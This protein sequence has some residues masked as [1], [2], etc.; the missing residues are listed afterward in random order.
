MLHDFL[1][2]RDV[3][4]LKLMSVFNGKIFIDVL[5]KTIWHDYKNA[6]IQARNRMQKLKKNFNL[7]LLKNTGLQ[8]PR[9]AFVMSEFCKDIV[10]TLFDISISSNITLSAVTAKH[11]SMEMISYYW[12]NKIG[13]DV[14]RTIVKEWSKSNKHTPD[15]FYTQNNKRIYVEIE[16]NLKSP[17]AYNSLF[18][19]LIKDDVYKILYV[20]ENEK[21]VKQFANNLPKSDKIM[22]ISIDEL[23]QNCS[24]NGKIGAKSQK[25]IIG[26]NK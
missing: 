22:I 12:L 10:R 25:E 8:S 18:V 15:L 20:V 23:I 2:E 9:S 4:I 6:P 24:V 17:G 16:R 21:R 19:N 5:A 7:F 3:E 13:R 14:K 1:T 26:E 11:M